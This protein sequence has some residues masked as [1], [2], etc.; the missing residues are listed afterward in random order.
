MPQF[1]ILFLQFGRLGRIWDQFRH[2]RPHGQLF[3]GFSRSKG[4]RLVLAA[5][6]IFKMAVRYIDSAVPN[7]KEASRPQ[8]KQLL[9]LAP[10]EASSKEASPKKQFSTPPTSLRPLPLLR[11]DENDRAQYK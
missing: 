9:L 3:R 8:K 7:A 4:V 6:V 5:V 11:S 10:K 1:L 2:N